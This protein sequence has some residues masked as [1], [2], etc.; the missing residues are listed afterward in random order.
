MI[1]L[2]FQYSAIDARGRQMRGS[3]SAIDRDDAYRKIV[4]AG[5]KPLRIDGQRRKRRKGRITLHTLSQLTHQLAVISEARIPITEGLRSIAEEE[6]NERLQAILI[7]VAREIESGKTITDSLRPHQEIFGEVY[8]ETMHAAEV[9]GNLTEVLARLAEMLEE[10]HTLRRN[11]RGALMYPACVASTLALAVTFL[12]MFVVPRFGAM[13]EQRGIPLPVPTQ[14]VIGISTVLTTYWWAFASA[15]VVGI[16]A[17]R[18]S[19][20]RPSSRS[21]IDAILHR[22]PVLSD[23]LKGIAVGRF[24]T[25][26]G[27][28]LRSGISLIDA[29]EMAGRACGRPLLQTDAERLRDHVSQG[30]RLKQGLAACAYLPTFGVRMISA[31]EESGNLPRMCGIVAAQ[32]QKDVQ[33]LAKNVSTII[34]PILVVALAAIVLLIALAVF[35]PMWNMA[36]LLG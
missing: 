5:L 24:V 29:I 31:G 28:G 20:R 9:S 3:M 2:S 22:I 14:I 26:L 16:I 36:A 6:T 23:L 19:W 27:L 32:Y 30:G 12:M 13:F 35:L 10:Q 18:K 4:A 33:H 17:L 7:D 11:V 34:E 25:V 1:Q 21:R 15:I 8:I